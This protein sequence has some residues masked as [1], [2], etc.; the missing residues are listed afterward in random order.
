MESVDHLPTAVDGV[1]VVKTDKGR[2]PYGVPFCEP[3]VLGKMTQQ[4]SHRISAKGT[5]PFKCVHFNII[6]EEDRFNGDTYIAHFWYDYTKYH[7]AFPIK[8]HEQKTLLP[9]FK[10]IM[11]FTKKFNT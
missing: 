9:L 5:Y 4:I 10:S 3:C 11:A 7:H 1:K 6:M 8:N 2:T